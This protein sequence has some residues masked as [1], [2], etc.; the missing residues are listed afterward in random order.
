[1]DFLFNFLIA[2]SLKRASDL[3]ET[4]SKKTNSQGPLLAVNLA[5]PLLCSKSLFSGC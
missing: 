5:S 4:I 3:D 1:M 2:F